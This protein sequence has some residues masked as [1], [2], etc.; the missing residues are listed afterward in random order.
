MAFPEGI[1]EK[2]F[3]EAASGRGFISKEQMRGPL[4]HEEIAA[5]VRGRHQW[6]CELKQ[7]EIKYRPFRD[8]WIILLLTVQPKIFALPLPKLVPTKIKAQYEIEDEFRRSS[9][10]LL[11]TE[12]RHTSTRSGVS[13]SEIQ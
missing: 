4:T 13:I 7:W 12:P 2:M 9:K 3:E 5:A 6:N 8:Y 10:L 1:V 11:S